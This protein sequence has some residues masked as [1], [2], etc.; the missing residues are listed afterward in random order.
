M[1]ETCNI[2]G[3]T[4]D[5]LNFYCNEGLIPNVKRNKS[6]YRVFDENDINRIKSLSCLKNC[7]MSISIMKKYIELCLNGESSITER[8]DIINANLQELESKKNKKCKMQLTIFI[9]NKIFIIKFYLVKQNI[10]VT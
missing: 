1:K 2:T 8:H 10:L 3:L 5:A 6:N 7:G 9:G 4:Y